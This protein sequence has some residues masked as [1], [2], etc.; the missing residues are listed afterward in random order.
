MTKRPKFVAATVTLELIDE[1]GA[2][3]ILNFPMTAIDY[4]HEEGMIVTKTSKRPNGEER[5]LI[6]AWRNCKSFDDFVLREDRD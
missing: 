4:T 5:L 3:H 2:H 6:K 1:E